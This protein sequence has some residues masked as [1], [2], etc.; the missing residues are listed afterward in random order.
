MVQVQVRV[1]VESGS[2]A[3]RAGESGGETLGGWKGQVPQKKTPTP[4]AP[5]T[6]HPFQCKPVRP[7][8]ELSLSFRLKLQ[9]Q[10]GCL[11]CKVGRAYMIQT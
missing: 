4:R 1:R 9:K 5:T 8:W 6:T 2:C 3:C 10:P 7:P 11:R